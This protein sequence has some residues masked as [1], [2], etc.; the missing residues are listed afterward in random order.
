MFLSENVELLILHRNAFADCE[1]DEDEEVVLFL[2]L[3]MERMKK[4]AFLDQLSNKI[5]DA[6]DTKFDWDFENLVLE[7]VKELGLGYISVDPIRL[8]FWKEAGNHDV[9]CPC[10]L[11]RRAGS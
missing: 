4:A 3:P 11:G 1:S 8:W 2:K 10:E 5:A 6:M 9:E 7:S